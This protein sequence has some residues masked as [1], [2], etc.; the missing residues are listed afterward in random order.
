MPLVKRLAALALLCGFLLLGTG[1]AEYLHNLAHAREDAS[2]DAAAIT[3]GQPVRHHQHDDSNCDLHRQ[4]HLPILS[5]GWLPLLVCL[6]LFIAFLSLI[7][8]PP[9]S[10]RVPVRLDCRGP[11]A[12]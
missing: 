3:A 9:I 2:A 4:L 5:A 7:T 1:T 11:P 8:P 6:G 10:C 12:C